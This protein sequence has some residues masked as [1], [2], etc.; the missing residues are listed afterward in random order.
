MRN[1]RRKKDKL[2]FIKI[3]NIYAL[4]E[5]KKKTPSGR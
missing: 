5:K 3:K 2:N 4:K 1:K